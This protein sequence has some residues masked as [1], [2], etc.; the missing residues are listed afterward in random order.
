MAFEKHKRLLNKELD[1]FNLILSEILPRYIELMKNE[2]ISDE[3]AKELGEIEHFLIEINAKIADIKSKLDHDLFGET[4]SEYY[5]VKA[6][7][8]AGD[9]NAIEKLKKLR[10]VFSESIKSDVFFNWN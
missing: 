1:Q 2:Q 5:K 4:M 8:T 10:E 7:A 9:K 3:E 6:K